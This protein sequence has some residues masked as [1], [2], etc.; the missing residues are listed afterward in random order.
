MTFEEEKKIYTT[1]LD[2]L[3]D[4]GREKKLIHYYT[5]DMVEMMRKVHY[6]GVPASLWLLSSSTQGWCYDRVTLLAAALHDFPFQVVEG[7][8]EGIRYLDPTVEEQI[9][10]GEELDEHYNNHCWLEVKDLKN[11]WWVVD[12]GNGIC[13]QKEIWYAIEKPTITFV[14]PKEKYI[15][16]P[17][18]IDAFISGK[19]D[20][21]GPF[22]I[23]PYLE[24]TIETSTTY[25]DAL[26]NEI[27]L[28]KAECNYNA[29]CKQ[30]Y[31][32]M[33]SLGLLKKGGA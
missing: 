12:P 22:A 11:I 30:V 6:G 23:I 14:C 24:K 13:F 19:R 9:R 31:L 16:N 27:A 8:I 1:R 10:N 28:F 3:W 33:M 32:D 5:K 15:H 18:Y 4:Y 7:D 17:E 26:Q 25:S 20:T 29:L 2:E 21:F